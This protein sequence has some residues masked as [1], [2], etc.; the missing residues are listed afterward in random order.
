MS[1]RLLVLAHFYKCS[2]AR[3]LVEV[4][5]LKVLVAR[6]ANFCQCSCS[7]RKTLCSHARKCS[8]KPFDTPPST[9]KPSRLHKRLL[10]ILFLLPFHQCVLKE[11]LDRT[12]PSRAPVFVGLASLKM[13][14]VR[15]PLVTMATCVRDQSVRT[16]RVAMKAFAIMKQ[17]SA[18]ALPVGQVQLV[19]VLAVQFLSFLDFLER[20]VQKGIILS[21][22]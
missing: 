10:I 12:V 18:D 20:T 19:S 3:F 17:D 8:Q 16:A 14:H 6:K 9:Q 21:T 7:Q 5:F 2:H 11:R 1:A 22:I 13:A 15:A 4:G